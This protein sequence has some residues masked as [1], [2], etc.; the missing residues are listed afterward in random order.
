MEQVIAVLDSRDR[1]QAALAEARQQVELAR[2]RLLRVQSVAGPEEIAARRA[3]VT[4]LE[5][6]LAGE[7]Q[8][9]QAAIARLDA[10]MRGAA[11]IPHP[12]SILTRLPLRRHQP[13]A[14]RSGPEARPRLRQ[15]GR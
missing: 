3:V 14:V 6:Q 4:R 10:E 1:L 8:T 13:S 12:A 11:M 15:E 9:Q 5:A 2:A 7:R